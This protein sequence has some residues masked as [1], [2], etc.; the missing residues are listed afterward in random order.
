MT[1]FLDSFLLPAKYFDDYIWHGN[2][3]RLFFLIINIITI[4]IIVIIIISI[5]IPPI[6]PDIAGTAPEPGAVAVVTVLA[7]VD[8]GVGIV[9]KTS[10]EYLEVVDVSVG[11]VTY[12]DPL[13]L[14]TITVLS[15]K[16]YVIY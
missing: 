9:V 2:Y 1:Y 6:P 15:N 16:V 10:D 8:G 14:D 3:L 11:K 13:V 7:V 5:T 12:D 4:A